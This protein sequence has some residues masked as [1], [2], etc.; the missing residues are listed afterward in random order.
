MRDSRIALIYEGTNEIQAI[1]LLMRKVLDR[2]QRLDLL[3][4]VFRSEVETLRALPDDAAG[5]LQTWAATLAAE[6]ETIATATAA[7]QT[8]RTAAPDRPFLVADDYLHALGHSLLAWSWARLAR[9]SLHDTDT[10]RRDWL[11]TVTQHGRT[12]LLPAA[13]WR[14][15]RVADGTLHLGWLPA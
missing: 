1:D 15:Q 14:W 5:T 7:L 11:H 8:G 10:A 3:L 6:V 12:W 2:P 9:A 13:R 4:D